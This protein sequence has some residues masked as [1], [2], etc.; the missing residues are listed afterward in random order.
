MKNKDNYDEIEDLQEEDFTLDDMNDSNPESPDPAE[1]TD[2]PADDA[3]DGYDPNQPAPDGY[4]ADDYD[5]DGYV[6]DDNNSDAYAGYGSDAGTEEPADDWEEP[7]D[8]PYTEDSY[9]DDSQPGDSYAEDSYAEDPYAGDGYADDSYA[10]DSYDE[11]FFEDDLYDEPYEDSYEPEEPPRKKKKTSGK[12]TSK[13]G[14]RKKTK[15]SDKK[16]SKPQEKKAPAKTRDDF[17][18][19]DFDEYDDFDDVPADRGGYDDE[20]YDEYY[21]DEPLQ[22][23]EKRPVRSTSPSR[24]RRSGS[25][26]KTSSVD[27]FREWLS[28]NLRYF[29]LGGIVLLILL[30]IVFAIRGCGKKGPDPDIEQPDEITTTVEDPG[31]LGEDAVEEE[32]IANPL[33][34]AESG[35][36]SLVNER[37]AAL[38]AGNTDGVRALQTDL[39][40]VDEA[41]IARDSQTV[42]SYTTKD[43]YTKEGL[44][45]GTYVTYVNY[46]TNYTGYSTPVPMLDE[47]YIMTTGDGSLIVNSDAQ[48]DPDISAYMTQLRGDSDVQQ[49]MSS[50]QGAHDSALASD[51][52][53]SAFLS[54]MGE[55]VSAPE[56]ES[57]AEAGTG[58][59]AAPEYDGPTVTATDDVY[60]RS[61]PGGDIIDT[62]PYGVSV[63]Y[64][65]T[66][67]ENNDW[68]QV[69]YN[70][71]TGYAY[72]DYLTE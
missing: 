23:E 63:K 45:D 55:A 50:V 48:T 47:L 22:E 12:T 61:E 35:I 3:P 38:A 1:D 53:L 19:A 20:Y 41:K 26:K 62:I 27:D 71:Q 30:V 24:P 15:S 56:A 70:G 32:M 11:D 10:D 44:T 54:G 7:Y 2:Y 36:V 40:A 46:D 5:A 16:K 69:E 17:D 39:S 51:P 29:M 65:G 28:D 34:A 68:Y 37:F 66:G 8:E 58:E 9:P 42:D 59:S 52:D 43:V 67:G 60:L 57:S 4:N 6:P 64:L 72:S 33:T 31:L 13:S 18:D 25:I 21:D 49:L 14:D